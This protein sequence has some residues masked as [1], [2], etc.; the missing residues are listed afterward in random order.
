MLRADA[1]VV[2]T[3]AH[4]VRQR[5][6]PRVVLQHIAEGSLQDA[7]NAAT[8]FLESCSVLAECRS[9]SSCF[10]ADQLHVGVAEEL[11]EGSDGVRSAADTG[12]DGCRQFALL[13][14]HLALR[15]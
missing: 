15:L 10:D 4:G 3:G 1:G 7:G 6:L 8:Y 9:A 12:H 14:Q 5:D 11:V 13:L 2:E